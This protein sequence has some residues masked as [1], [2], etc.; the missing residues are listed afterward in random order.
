MELPEI[1]KSADVARLFPVIAETGKEQRAASIFLSV[2][3][4]VPPF[5]HAILSHVGQRIGARTSINTYTEVVLQNES[6]Q[7]RSNRP[8]GLIELSTGKRRWSALLEAKIGSSP[9][10]QEQIERYLRLARDNSVDALITVS[11]QLAALP[12]HHPL[13]VP[14]AL[15]RKS[16]LYHFSWTFILTEAVLLHEQSALDDAEQAF[17][18][19]EFIRFF[20]HPSAGVSGFVSMPKE[21]GEA[22]DQIRAGARIKKG[23]I[24][25][26]I[27]SAWY[28]E[29]RDLSL[30]MSRMVGCNISVKLS[31]A[32]AEDAEKRLR[33]DVDELC[34]SGKLEAHLHVPNTASDITVIADLN[35]RSLRAS[36]RLDAPKDRKTTKA[37]LNW[38]LRQIKNVDPEGIYVGIIWS[39]RATNSVHR[40]ADLRENPDL[41]AAP[42]SKSEARAFEVT[43]TGSSAK[44]FIG[45]RT[46][47]EELEHLVPTFYELVGQHLQA[48]KP[49][50]PKPKHSVT[51]DDE[52]K[53][54]LK[55]KETASKSTGV[56]GNA[57]A[58]LLEIPAFLK[59]TEG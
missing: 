44:R 53:S 56:A 17:L 24:G 4:A 33:D 52:N 16:S 7:G 46:V 57:H 30:L 43:L 25:Q 35:G 34:K 48:W 54:E 12:T 59:R 27:V 9:L 11:N 20:S 47:I 18:L 2:L 21:W 40:L 10:D 32:H 49:T 26:Q 1:L 23:D 45:R 51:A 58:D 14:K 22:V 50:P 5:A 29:L 28:Q 36:M 37:R 55:E 39:S 41:V 19:R 6:P 38:L 8:D 15:T 13:D 42:S 3:S 31:R